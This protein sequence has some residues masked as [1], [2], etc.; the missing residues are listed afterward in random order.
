[1]GFPEPKFPLLYLKFIFQT[2][3]LFLVVEQTDSCE[4]HCHS[5]FVTCFDHCV[6]SHRA[7]WLCDKFHAALMCAFDVITEREECIRSECYIGKLI[8]SCTFLFFCEDCRLL[9]EYVLPCSI[10][11]NIHVFVAD[12]NIDRIVA[13]CSADG[14]FEWK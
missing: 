9:C 11:Q 4:R 14:I 1:M 8:E 13:L 6:I 12:I 5:I 10:C 7:T 2:C 3:S